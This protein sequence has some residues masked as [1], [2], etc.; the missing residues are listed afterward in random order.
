MSLQLFSD[1]QFSGKN[2]AI[3]GFPKG[4]YENCLFKNCNFNSADLRHVVFMDCQFEQCD[5]SNIKVPDTAFKNV[6][7]GDCK[8]LGVQFGECNDFLLEMNFSNCQLNLTSFYKL[9]L[10]GIKF[11]NCDL[12][13]ADLTEADLTNSKFADCDLMG[14]VFDRTKLD[15]SDLY[16]AYN[17]SINP[18]INSIK[19]AHFSSGNIQGLVSHLDIKV[20]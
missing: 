3:E 14:A 2:Y 1:E 13:E 6:R 7:F 19:K 18:E 10:K 17:F 20:D 11:I 16:T 8:L 9:K 4:E 12:R 15:R 5:L